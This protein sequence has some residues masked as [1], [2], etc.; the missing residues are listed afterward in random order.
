[1]SVGLKPFLQVQVNNANDIDSITAC[2]PTHVSFIPI[3]F[4]KENRYVG[5]HRGNSPQVTSPSPSLSPPFPV[6]LP[7]HLGYSGARLQAE[8]AASMKVQRA[9]MPCCCQGKSEWKQKD[10]SAGHLCCCGG[11]KG[12]QPPALSTA[13]GWSLP[14]SVSLP[15]AGA[16]GSLPPPTH[17]MGHLEEWSSPRRE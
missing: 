10:S 17:V 3:P 2:P 6:S 7:G 11:G 8:S 4:K 12:S 1:M 14:L 15:P 5:N 9:K 13:A 16:C